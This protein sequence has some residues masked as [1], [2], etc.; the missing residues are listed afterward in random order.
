MVGNVTD[1]REVT[2]PLLSLPGCGRIHPALHVE[3]DGVVLGRMTADGRYRLVT[4][5]RT[6]CEVDDV[7]D[8][9][10]FVP[11]PHLDLPDRW[12]DEGVAEGLPTR[13]GP[14]LTQAP[15]PVLRA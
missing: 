9:L 15:P 14:T 4:S 13:A 8:R 11:R 2:A 12:E 1:H 5:Q 3:P 10:L 6:V 7:R